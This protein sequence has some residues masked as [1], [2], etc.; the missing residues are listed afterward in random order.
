MIKSEDYCY[1]IATPRL[2]FEIC[3]FLEDKAL[4]KVISTCSI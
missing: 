3:M 2:M 4:Y 1:L